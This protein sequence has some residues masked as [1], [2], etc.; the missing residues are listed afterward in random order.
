G[1]IQNREAFR[2]HVVAALKGV[3]ALDEQTAKAGQPAEERYLASYPFHPDLTEIFYTKWTNLEGFQRTRGVLRTFALALRDAE[4][5]DTCPLVGVNAFLGAPEGASGI[6]EAAREL[7]NIAETE[8]YEGKRQEWSAILLGE[9][10]KARAIQHDYPG[11]AHRELEQAVMATFLHSQPIGHHALTRELLLL[12]G[13]TR[14]DRI[15]L[16]KALRRWT[17]LS[18]FLDEDVMETGGGTE[19]SLPAAWRLG[20]R[21]NLTQMHDDACKY[22]VPPELV[23]ARLIEEIQGLKS[24]TLGAKGPGARVHVLP[25]SPDQIADDGDF[26]YVILPPEA[27]CDAGK[28]ADLAQRFLD[29]TT[30]PDKPRVY[31]NA[32][33]LAAPSSVGL[34]QVRQSIV[35]YL[36]WEE[37]RAQLQPQHLD[38]SDPLRWGMLIARLD[39]TRKAIPSAIRQ[40]YSIVVTV[41]EANAVEAFKVT[42]GSDSL[43]T[44]IKNDPRARIQ[45]TAISAEAL[46]PGGPYELWRGDETAR[47]LKDLVGAFAQHPHLPKMLNAQAIL[48][49]LIHGCVDGLFVFRLKRP[50]GSVRTFWRCRPEEAVLKEPALEVV[51]PEAA[52]L[53]SLSPSLLAP[54]VLPELWQAAGITVQAVYGYFAG[55]NV[56]QV[57][58]GGYQEPL[59]IP[60]A[61]AEVVNA[62]I[63][64]AVTNGQ[65]W[66]LSGPASIWSESIPAGLLSPDARLLPPPKPVALG[67]LLPPSLPEAWQA[68]TTTALAIDAALSKRAG[69]NLPW[70]LVRNAIEAA[71]KANYLERTLDSGPW[72]CEYPGAQNVKLRAPGEAPPPLKPSKPGVRL[73]EA[74][75]KTNELQDLGD[76]M[77]ELGK[78]AAG[79]DLRLHVRV[80]LSGDPPE[81]VVDKVNEV[82]GEV[83]EALR[84]K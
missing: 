71:L 29:E 44:T 56:V 33:V 1:S 35:N 19:E 51:L 48:D 62:A 65:L 7:T 34:E 67:E 15:E 50:D 11:L 70:R 61:P 73:G 58:K 30:G 45:E 14:S 13:H 21:P 52:V 53:T 17:E 79:Y 6:S 74:E 36:A 75:L 47:W 10:E 4:K 83:S 81:A 60:S 39:A 23:Q 68:E 12:L 37:V 5:W 76:A 84:V 66:L 77:E 43:F 54:G 42:V 2:P 63:E 27:A 3:A 18:W 55:G 25:Q 40:A 24:L 57:Q 78:A 80:E 46:L 38:K 64:E 82:L 20:S 72:P 41:S 28:P 69:E 9:L 49:T 26:H 16:E 8:E 59:S 32:L 31:R 22:R